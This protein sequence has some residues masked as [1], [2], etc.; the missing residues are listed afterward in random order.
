MNLMAKSRVFLLL[1]LTTI[2]SSGVGSFFATFLLHD[3][4]AFAI[5]GSRAPSISSAEEFRLVDADGHVR[6]VL[7]LSSE[8]E[9]YLS[10]LDHH[11]TRRVW[12][13][14]GQE[15]GVAVRDVDGKTRLMLSVDG[16]GL[17]SLV[18]RDRQHQ[19]RIF[20]PQ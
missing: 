9:P 1:F 20:Q 11:D 17:P 3:Q 5:D 15:S 6:A 16:G 7:A 14:I 19:S 13:G 10:F 12:I 4:L 18:V 2:L 8:G